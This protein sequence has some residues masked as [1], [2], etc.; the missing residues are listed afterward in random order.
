MVLSELEV[1]RT[2]SYSRT[3]DCSFIG[4]PIPVFTR[5]VEVHPSRVAN[6]DRR[7]SACGA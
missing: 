3:H 7:F 1:F 5:E 4:S 6:C 2:R